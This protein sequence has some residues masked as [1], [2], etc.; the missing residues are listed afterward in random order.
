MADADLGEGRGG[1]RKIKR[2]QTPA[3]SLFFLDRL[4]L[5]NKFED[6]HIRHGK[7]G[8]R[9]ASLALR[10]SPLEERFARKSIN[11]ESL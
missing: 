5:S 6:Q 2:K 3:E 8:T 1:S 10:R 4:P 9:L 7:E 11:G